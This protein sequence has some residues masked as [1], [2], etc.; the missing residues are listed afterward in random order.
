MKLF[1]LVFIG[2]LSVLVGVVTGSQQASGSQKAPCSG[3]RSAG[4]AK[5]WLS[6]MQ[7]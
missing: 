6:G 7:T 5:A 2:S 3:S 1:T 4:S